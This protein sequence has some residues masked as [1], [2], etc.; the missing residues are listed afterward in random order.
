M[1]DFQLYPIAI[2]M[3]DYGPSALGAQVKG[4]KPPCFMSQSHSLPSSAADFSIG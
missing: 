4:Q 1:Q 2:E 3:T